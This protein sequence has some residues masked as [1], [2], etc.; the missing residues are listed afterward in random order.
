MLINFNFILVIVGLLICFGGI[1]FR[2]VCSVLMGA[3]G[4]A[5]CSLCVL[6]LTIGIW[7]IDNKTLMIVVASA[8]ICALFSAIYDR[9]CAAFNAFLSVFFALVLILFLMDSME[10][11]TIMMIAAVISIVVAILSYQFYLAAY[12]IVTAFSGAFLASVGGCGL[13][14]DAEALEVLRALMAGD[15]VGGIILLSTLILGAV[16]GIV[17]N[18]RLTMLQM[19]SEHRNPYENGA[20]IK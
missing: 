17:Q 4:G 19:A 5:V 11:G 9:L 16:G 15:E 8:I 18:R 12:V 10:I 2:K 6:L 13:Y 3:L 1:Y 14:F 7:R 20:E